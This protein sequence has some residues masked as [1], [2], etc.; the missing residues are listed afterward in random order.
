MQKIDDVEL[1]LRGGLISEEEACKELME[2]MFLNKQF[3]GL[4]LLPEDD[5]LDFLEGEYK[6]FPRIFRVFDPKLSSFTNFLYTTIQGNFATWKKRKSRKESVELTTLYS[7]N[8]NLTEKQIQFSQQES[9][10]NYE[11]REETAIT[12]EKIREIQ[13]VLIKKKYGGKEATYTKERKRQKLNKYFNIRRKAALVLMLKC[14]HYITDDL[15]KKVSILTSL[16]LKTLEVLCEKAKESIVKK[17]ERREK[18]EACRDTAFFYHIRFQQELNLYSENEL[19]Y[20]KI[21]SRYVKKTDLWKVK[22]DLLKQKEFSVSP[23]NRVVAKILGLN[24]RQVSYILEQAQINMDN[25]S[26]KDY[27]DDHEDIFSNR[28]P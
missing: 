12:N 7:Q 10:V 27:Y 21:K 28:K 13:S 2:V 19:I 23:S 8:A 6:K 20:N 1:K 3:F 18:V 24:E 11:I 26:L 15:L 25:I 9:S 5:F 14:C 4:Q 16:P 17:L 22:N